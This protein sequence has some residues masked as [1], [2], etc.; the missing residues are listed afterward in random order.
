MTITEEKT[1]LC[2]MGH[3][4]GFEPGTAISLLNTFGSARELFSLPEKELDNLFGAYSKYKGRISKKEVDL[5]YE[6]LSGLSDK[7]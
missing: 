2:A 7:G 1:C 3:I 5:A 6:E 4:F